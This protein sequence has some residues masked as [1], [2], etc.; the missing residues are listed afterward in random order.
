MICP[1]LPSFHVT[2]ASDFESGAHVAPYSPISLVLTRAGLPLGRSITH[3]RSSAVKASFV[4]SGDGAMSRTWCD[5]K[6]V[7][8]STR[9]VNFTSGPIAI[10]TSAEN[11]IFVAALR[12]T[13]T[14]QISPP[15]E[16]TIAFE[17]GVNE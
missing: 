3:M 4:P 9:Y 1:P 16:T 14:R 12:S 7:L 2:Y 13:G 17:S 11:G 6:V 5:V 8:V 15:Y 10:F